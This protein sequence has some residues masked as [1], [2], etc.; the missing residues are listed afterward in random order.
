MNEI[1]VNKIASRFGLER[2]YLFRIFKR[3]LGIGVKEYITEVKMI[4]AEQLLAQGYSVS[5]CAAMVGYSDPF[6][7]SRSYKKRHSTPPKN[8]RNKT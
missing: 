6:N 4:R 7:F 8:A 1:S 5:E 2:S 3:K